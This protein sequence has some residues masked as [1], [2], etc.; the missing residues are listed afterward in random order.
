MGREGIGGGH[1][2][3]CIFKKQPGLAIGPVSPSPSFSRHLLHSL[4]ITWESGRVLGL[5]GVEDRLPPRPA[6]RGDVE[7]GSCVWGKK[8]VPKL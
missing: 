6:H 2:G 8:K 4:G 5:F 7:T 1:P 3:T